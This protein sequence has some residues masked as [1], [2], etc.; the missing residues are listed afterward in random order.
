MTVGGEAADEVGEPPTPDSEASGLEPDDPAAAPLELSSRHATA[1]TSR[2]TANTSSRR[3]QYTREGN[4]PEGRIRLLMSPTLTAT[5]TDLWHHRCDMPHGPAYRPLVAWYDSAARDLPWRRPGTGGWEVLVSEVMLQQTPV[6]RV[7][8][9][10]AAWL[11]RW[12]T[13]AALARDSVGDALRMWGRLGYP[14]RAARLWQA[15]RVIDSDF[16][17]VVPADPEELRSLPGVG[18]YTA[19]AVAAFAYR[20]RTVVLDTNVR[21]VL[22]RLVLG[23]QFPQRSL[24]SQ[25][26]EAAERLVPD[27]GAQAASWSVAAMELGAL[28]CTARA[29]RCERC[30]VSELCVWRAEGYPAYAGPRRAGQTYTGTDRHCRGRILAALRSSDGPVDRETLSVSWDDAVQRERAINS[31]LDDGLVVQM[32]DSA[33]A[34]P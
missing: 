25:E 8:P 9:V 27:D 31:L 11:D 12:P 29:P 6:E 22:A 17:G 26:R 3:T 4:G 14:R 10:Y 28:V 7:L 20:R 33:L 18:E 1:T 2:T 23:E 24:T 15:A 16:E 30:P 19:A 21:R 34:L 5:N 13:P 32:G